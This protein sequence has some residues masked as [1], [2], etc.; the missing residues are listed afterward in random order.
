MLNRNYVVPG[1]RLIIYVDC[2]YNTQ[3][4]LS[5]IASEDTG[6]TKAGIPYL[7]KYPKLFS[8][9]SIFP[10]ARLL[11]MSKFFLSVNEVYS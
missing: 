7:Y 9:V 2:K 5:F 4:V 6:I 3:K 1:N 10:V 8:N 11:G